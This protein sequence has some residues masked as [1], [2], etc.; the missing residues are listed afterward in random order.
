VVF[1]VLMT[2]CF[3]A[4][5]IGAKLA[6][7]FA[8]VLVALWVRYGVQSAGMTLLWLVWLGHRRQTRGLAFLRT[9]NPRFQA[10][11]GLLLLTCS[12]LSFTGVRY[13]PVAEFTAIA[14][15]TPFV[16]TALAAR[17]LHEAVRPLQWAL[18]AL[19]FLGALIVI[20][21]GSGVLG[22]AVLF[23]L[24]LALAYGSFQALTRRLSADEDPYATHFFTGWVGTL[25]LTPLLFA[26]VPDA[27]GLMA[28]LSAGQWALLL[29][30]G[31]CGTVGHFLLIQAYSRAPAASLAPFTYTQLAFVALGAGWVFGQ[32]PDGW[33]WLGMAVIASAGVASAVLGGGAARARAG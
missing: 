14:F 21:P 26:M 9:P 3:A 5:D 8:P 25:V 31:L 27:L 30:V 17:L 28:G 20:R 29:F 12:A 19:G 15:L 24:G 2:A 22:W 1:I 4:L 33:G 23:P 7:G 16:A 18:I 13:M 11:R 10:L 6:G 32:W